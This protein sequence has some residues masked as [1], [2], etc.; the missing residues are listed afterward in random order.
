MVAR[1]SAWQE[2]VANTT[3]AINNAAEF[4]AEIVQR[5]RDRR[6]QAKEVA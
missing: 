4:T 5:L 3:V 2:G 1:C 6:E